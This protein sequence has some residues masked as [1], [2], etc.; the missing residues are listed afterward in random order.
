MIYVVEGLTLVGLGF[1]LISPPGKFPNL[2]LVVF[3]VSLFITLW[4][5]SS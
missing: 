5:L 1:Y 3:G 4:R 2:G